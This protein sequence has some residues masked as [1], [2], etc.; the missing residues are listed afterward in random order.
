MPPQPSQAFAGPAAKPSKI[1]G[2]SSTEDEPCINSHRG[3]SEL[4]SP[5]PKTL[6]LGRYCTAWISIT[7]KKE[8]FYRLPAQRPAL[9]F[10][11]LLS[12]LGWE[13][14]GLLSLEEGFKMTNTRPNMKANPSIGIV[15]R[16]TWQCINTSRT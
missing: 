6:L 5:F 8:F 14:L 2:H 15:T 7:E 13:M 4:I 12:G 1:L 10:T 9:K 16:M 3:L 11:L